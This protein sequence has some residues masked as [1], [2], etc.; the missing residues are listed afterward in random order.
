M[1]AGRY[2]IVLFVFGAQRGV[3]LLYSARNERR[4]HRRQPGAPQAG[5]SVFKWIALVNVGLFT[6]PALERALRRRPAPAPIAAMGWAAAVSAVALRLSVLLSLRGSWTVRAVVPTDLPVV[7]RGPYRFIRHPNYV[8]LGLEFLGL[9][10]I[11]GAYLSALGLGVAN[12]V[13]LSRRIREEDALLMA[14][15]AYRERMGEKPRFVPRLIS[16]R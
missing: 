1:T 11:G 13:L 5:R 12:A 10:L 3:E 9:P 14:I 2:A 16:G 6:V 4:I 8:A 15:P 7:D